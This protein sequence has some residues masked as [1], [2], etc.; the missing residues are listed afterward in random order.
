MITI[1]ISTDNPLFYTFLDYESYKIN[2]DLYGF[3]T[4]KRATDKLSYFILDDLKKRSFDLITK[5][6]TLEEEKEILIKSLPHPSYHKLR[7]K[8]VEKLDNYFHQDSHKKLSDDQQFRFTFHH[9]AFRMF[10]LKD[11]MVHVTRTIMETKQYCE[12]NQLNNEHEMKIDDQTLEDLIYLKNIFQSQP[13]VYKQLEINVEKEGLYVKERDRKIY[14]DE[15][16]DEDEL[17]IFLVMNRSKILH[18]YEKNEKLSK[19]AIILITGLYQHNV[20][21]STQIQL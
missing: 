1:R 16:K 21:Y 11:E 7:K 18:V 10:Y 15:K 4:I 3:S 6:E 17:L 5:N 2:D 9:E 12:E 13:V 20:T 8:I 14:V 19:D